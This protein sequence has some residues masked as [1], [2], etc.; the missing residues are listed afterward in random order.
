VTLQTVQGHLTAV[1]K[2]KLLYW[3]LQNSVLDFPEDGVLELK[4]VGVPYV[5]CHVYSSYVVLLASVITSKNNT[6]SIK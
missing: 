4:L 3:H 2:P 6:R 5:T 1:L